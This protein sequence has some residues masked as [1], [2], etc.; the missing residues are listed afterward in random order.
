MKLNLHVNS[1]GS[2]MSFWFK[3]LKTVTLRGVFNIND[4][5]GLRTKRFMVLD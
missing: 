2:L 4:V 3:G 1:N 5:F